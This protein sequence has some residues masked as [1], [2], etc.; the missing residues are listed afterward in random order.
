MLVVL[1]DQPGELSRNHTGFEAL[2][3]FRL[4]PLLDRLPDVLPPELEA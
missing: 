1:G 2:C 4:R 3:S